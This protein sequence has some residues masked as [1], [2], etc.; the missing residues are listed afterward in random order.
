MSVRNDSDDMAGD[1]MLIEE[2]DLSR[3]NPIE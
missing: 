2:M 3:Y 1:R